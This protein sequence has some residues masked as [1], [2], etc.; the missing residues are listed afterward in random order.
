MI[1]IELKMLLPDGAAAEALLASPA[2]AAAACGP[3]RRRALR[4]I[5]FD[6]PDGRLRAAGLALRLRKDGGRWL[7]TVKRAGAA[8]GAGGLFAPEEAETAAPGGRI[9]LSRLADP[10]LREAVEAA[11]GDAPLAAVFESVID[12]RMR[13]LEMPS[14]RVELA[15]DVGELVAGERRAALVEAELELKAGAPEA[16]YEAARAVMGEGAWRFSE[17]SKAAR[18][19]AL[20]AGAPAL[21]PPGA[22]KAAT[23]PLRRGTTAEAAA[24]AVLRETLAQIDANAAACLAADDPKGS[25][26]LRVGLR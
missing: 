13:D 2:L 8:A 4:S 20:A 21:P 24:A 18:G 1:E 25:H 14:G 11:R 3:A 7:Q 22:R 23:V 19:H 10:A 6:T 9:D 15:V 5:Y 26:Q 17:R 16:V 12:R